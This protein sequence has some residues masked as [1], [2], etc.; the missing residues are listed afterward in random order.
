MI[1][2]YGGCPL[3]NIKKKILFVL[4]TKGD[5]LVRSSLEES[6]EEYSRRKGQSVKSRD[7]ALTVW[8]SLRFF[9][10]EIQ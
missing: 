8:P 1:A 5:I 9:G 4:A 7:L 6:A 10:C 2:D 3:S